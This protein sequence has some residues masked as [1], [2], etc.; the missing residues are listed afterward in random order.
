[1]VIKMEDFKTFSVYYVEN[2]YNVH[3]LEKIFFLI[4]IVMSIFM[5]HFS[6]TFIL[7]KRG[8]L[9]AIEIVTLNCIAPEGNKFDSLVFPEKSKCM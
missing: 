1:M 7:E 9:C 3:L 2:S 5:C 4:V 8:K 6:K